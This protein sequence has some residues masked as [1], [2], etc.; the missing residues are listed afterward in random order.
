L[1][2]EQFILIAMETEKKE[3]D[4]EA[5]G[6]KEVL[7]EVKAISKWQKEHFKGINEDLAA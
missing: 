3:L 6:F 2:K 1:Q 5:L 4:S 7:A